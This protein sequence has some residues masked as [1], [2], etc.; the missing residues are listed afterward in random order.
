[1]SAVS[2]GLSPCVL[3]RRLICERHQFLTPC[4]YHF[5]Y[6]LELRDFFGCLFAVDH[7]L[8]RG[9]LRQER[10][11]S[12]LKAGE[13]RKERPALVVK[14]KARRTVQTLSSPPARTRATLK[15]HDKQVAHCLRGVCPILSALLRENAV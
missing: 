7:L 12:F 4:I 2:P 11:R 9:S 5:V 13:E 10:K 8:P 3:I 14:K 15:R 6:A 1:M